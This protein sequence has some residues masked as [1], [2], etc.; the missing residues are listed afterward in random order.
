MERTVDRMFMTLPVSVD[1]F[2]HRRIA[3]NVVGVA[4]DRKTEVSDFSR[5]A[6][7]I[8]GVFAGAPF[9]LVYV[10]HIMMTSPGRG[11]ITQA[12]GWFTAPFPLDDCISPA[13]RA[14]DCAAER[15][16]CCR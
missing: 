4:H 10:A 8:K 15:K 16:K 13:R 2:L 7:G 1:P 12:F 9:P 11:R 5:I 6:E 14:G 3:E